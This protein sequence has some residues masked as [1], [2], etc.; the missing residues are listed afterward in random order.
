MVRSLQISR[1]GQIDDNKN[2][3]D[4]TGHPRVNEHEDILL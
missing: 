4:I 1:Q 3:P 2:H